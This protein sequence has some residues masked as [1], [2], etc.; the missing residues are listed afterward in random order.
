LVTQEYWQITG[1]VGEGTLMTFS[2][3]PRKNPDAAPVV[4][5][6]RD[7]GIEPEG[8]VLY[9]YAAI[10]TWAQA[11]EK[12][13]KTDFGPVVKA[14][15]TNKFNTVLGTIGF[16]EKGDVTAPGYVFYEWSNG[17]YDYVKK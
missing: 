15:N 3:D 5:R 6:F 1:E 12:A 10:Q 9:T 14:L 17:A 16:D 2:P 11:A 4:K 7:A 8:Y 13:G